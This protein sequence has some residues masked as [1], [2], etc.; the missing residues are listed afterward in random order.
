MATKIQ[1]LLVED[2]FIISDYM[3][4]CLVNLGYEVI[5]ICVSYDE[6]IAALQTSTPDI[7]LIDISIKGD[8]N[9]IDIGNYINQH[10]QIPFIF[11]SSHGDKNTIDKAKQTQ[12]YAYLIKPFTEEDLYAIIETALVHFSNKKP[13]PVTESDLIIINDGIFI[14][15]KGKF[16]KVPLNELFYIEANDN[17]VSLYTAT[18]NYVLKTSLTTLLSS[19]PD[20]FCRIQKSYIINLKE[21]KGFDSEEIQLQNKVL[22]IGKNYYESFIEKLKIVKG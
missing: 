16:M 18:S 4:E 22:P 1:I 10:L 9:G 13:K 5:A 11:T 14:K 20:Y 6:T 17:Y 15:H 7:A 2:E 19:L 12:P 21:L 3:Q 8:K